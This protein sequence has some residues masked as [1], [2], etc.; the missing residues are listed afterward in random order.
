[1]GEGTEAATWPAFVETIPPIAYVRQADAVGT[2]FYVS[3]QARALLG[4]GAGAFL[5]DR[6]CWLALVHPDDRSRV[7]RE[8]ARAAATG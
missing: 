4:R 7:M 2:F 3:P 6:Q 8:E 1:M 5:L